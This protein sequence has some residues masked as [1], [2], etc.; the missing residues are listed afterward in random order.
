MHNKFVRKSAA[1]EIAL[2]RKSSIH[3]PWSIQ[4]WIADFY[5]WI[6]FFLALSICFIV[7]FQIGICFSKN[8]YKQP[9]RVNQ[10]K[11]SHIVYIACCLNDRGNRHT[12]CIY[13]VAKIVRPWDESY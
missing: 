11:K 5:Q 8:V 3:K 4:F 9:L 6:E 10:S 13:T 1:G 7:H 12:K 2:S